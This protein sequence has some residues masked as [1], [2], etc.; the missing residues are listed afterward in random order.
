MGL[1]TNEFAAS[2]SS[3]P[4]YKLLCIRDD[5]V[6]VSFSPD[7]PQESF[8][9]S[10]IATFA[11]QLDAEINYLDGPGFGIELR[12]ENYSLAA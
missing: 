2:F 12:I 3:S 10:L 9:H 4:T 11:E 8:G 7:Q 1:L 5:G 6:G